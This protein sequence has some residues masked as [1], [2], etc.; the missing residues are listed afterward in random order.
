MLKPKLQYFGHLM[1]RADS[2]EKTLMLEKIEGRRRRGWQR[3]RWLYGITDSMD[4]NFGKLWVLVMDSLAWRAAVHG[5]AKNQT[6][7]RNWTELICHYAVAIHSFQWSCLLTSYIQYV[8]IQSH[9][10]VQLFA[11]PWTAARQ[12]S[13]SL[14]ISWSLPKFMSIAFVI[15]SNHLILWHPLLLLPS[16]F[17]SIRKFSNES[18]V[19]IRWPKYGCF[20]FRI[21]L[22]VSIQGWFPLWLTG[23][24]FLQSKGL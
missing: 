16:I 11:T 10:H 18:V 2:L 19:H 9:S 6:Q 3:M 15:P 12:A 20:S 24:I 1:W 8:V 7:L 23:L 13:L 14:T 4:M 21:I 22:S 5:V 17:P